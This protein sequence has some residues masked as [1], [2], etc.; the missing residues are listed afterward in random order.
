[1]GGGRWGV[2]CKWEGRMMCEKTN[3]RLAR[4]NGGG[5]QV[6][7]NWVCWLHHWRLVYRP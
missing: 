7:S 6:N 1:V 5:R 4:D 2:G 3:V